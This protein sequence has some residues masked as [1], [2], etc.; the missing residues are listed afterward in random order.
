MPHV[1]PGWPVTLGTAYLLAS[2]GSCARLEPLATLRPEPV[3]VTPDATRGTIRWMGVRDEIFPNER[4][5]AYVQTTWAKGWEY[6]VMG[7]GYAA[8]MLTEQREV[9]HA[10]VDQIGLAIVYVQRH[11]VELVI[12]QAL[13]D[14]GEG[15]VD[16]AK[17]GHNLQK[18][19]RRLGTVVSS[20]DAEHWRYLSNEYGEFLSAMHEADEGSFSYRYPIDKTGEASKRADF[21][22]LEA[23]ERHANSFEHGVQGY[24]YWVSETEP[25]SS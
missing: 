7:F 11:R 20:I 3:A 9:M 23:L 19:W 21:I 18:L 17:V 5:L 1:G 4:K 6:G 16:V 24:T 10:N 14:L 25:E 12:K 2:C 13:V 22:D 8:R 15:P